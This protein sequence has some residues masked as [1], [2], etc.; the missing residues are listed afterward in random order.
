MIIGQ[1]LECT[2]TYNA[3]FKELKIGP[4]W[5]TQSII[6]GGCHGQAQPEGRTDNGFQIQQSPS[7]M[8]AAAE[9]NDTAKKKKKKKKIEASQKT[10]GK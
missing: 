9:K 2:D 8:L 6:G 10:D 3:G 5:L 7:Q 4:S 1:I